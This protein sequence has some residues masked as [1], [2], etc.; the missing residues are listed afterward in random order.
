M[1]G[2]E[3]RNVCSDGLTEQPVGGRMVTSRERID[4]AS[5]RAA[6][7]IRLVSLAAVAV[8]LLALLAQGPSDR[9]APRYVPVLS[10]DSAVGPPHGGAESPAQQ[11][12][13]YRARRHPAVDRLLPDAARGTRFYADLD[14]K[15]GMAFLR[16]RAIG[17]AVNVGLEGAEGTELHERAHLMYAEQPRLVRALLRRLPPPDPSTY[18]AKND[19]E[20]FASM[21]DAAWEVLVE[22]EGLCR[23]ETSLE[24]LVRLERSVPGTA[25]FVAWYLRT[26][27]FDDDSAA[28]RDA[29]RDAVRAE[30]ERLTA[31]LRPQWE[32]LW[33]QLEA[34]REPDG[35]FIAGSH[36]KSQV[37]R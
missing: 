2:I 19:H 10:P 32:A 8:S 21:A 35:T 22:P 34:Q 16:A 33:Q 29:A 1:Y 6:R 26:G 3:S 36:G 30:A 37:T 28:T 9:V 14:G 11:V 25:G 24:I 20:H 12:A 17:I 23:A 13:A 31:T 27:A 7:T 15:S 4:P 18:A 5:G